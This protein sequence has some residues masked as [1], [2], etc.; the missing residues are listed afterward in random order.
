MQP[1]SG[2]D[3]RLN[4]APMHRLRRALVAAGGLFV[5]GFC[6][7]RLAH[8]L[9]VH[10]RSA[11]RI[12]VALVPHCP[13]TLRF[14]DLDRCPSAPAP[15]SFVGVV[16]VCVMYEVSVLVQ[17]LSLSL[18]LSAA[19]V[20][21]GHLTA[22]FFLSSVFRGHGTK[23]NYIYQHMKNSDFALWW[24]ML[25]EAYTRVVPE[26]RSYTEYVNFVISASTNT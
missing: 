4:K 3:W 23:K 22:N 6:T 15:A 5:G 25:E 21:R 7:E 20:F 9:H 13:I 11:T 18:S 14:L 16:W 10:D 26:S 24:E 2:R 19:S 17:T 1:G 8:L 12:S